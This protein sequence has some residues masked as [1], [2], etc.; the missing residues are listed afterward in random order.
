MSK[1]REYLSEKS[2]EKEMTDYSIALQKCIEHHVRD[3]VIPKDIAKQAPHHAKLLN[4]KLKK[5]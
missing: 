3:K 2:G 1:F 4:D 5:K